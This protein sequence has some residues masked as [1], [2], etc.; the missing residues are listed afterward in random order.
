MTDK[1]IIFDYSGTLSLEAAAF[2]RPDSLMQHLQKSGLFELAVN[3]TA[4]FWEIINSTWRQGSTTQLGYKTVVQERIAELFPEI[5]IIKQ[6]EISRAVTKFLCAYLDH[7]QIDECWQ[8]I[9][10]KLS[11]DK[12]VKVIIATDHYAEATETIIQNLEKWDIQ[13]TALASNIKSNFIVANSADIGVHKAESKFW[14]TLKTLCG[15]KANRILLIDDFGA[16][17]QSADAYSQ[18]KEIFQR[19]QKTISLLESVFSAQVQ[20]FIFAAINVL[21]ADLILQ[22]SKKILQFLSDKNNL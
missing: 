16:N 1:L 6:T 19:R 20:C 10:Q 11:A 2:S 22:A 13:A 14:E 8:K 9:L 15:I 18:K 3:N 5:A 4:L 7:F 21:V 12:S 17:E